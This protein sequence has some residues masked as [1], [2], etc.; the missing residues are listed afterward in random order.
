MQAVFFQKRQNKNL[1]SAGTSCL[2]AQDNDECQIIK[3]SP[4]TALLKRR[5]MCSPMQ[6]A[7]EHP[8]GSDL[9]QYTQERGEETIAE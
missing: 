7:Q 2:Q 9:A 8:K 5:E 3:R 6:C 1:L 4:K